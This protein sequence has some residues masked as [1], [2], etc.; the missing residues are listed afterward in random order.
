MMHPSIA[1]KYGLKPEDI[2]FAEAHIADCKRHGRDPEP[3]LCWWRDHG[4]YMAGRPPVEIAQSFRDYAERA[5]VSDADIE[6]HGVWHETVDRD[7]LQAIPPLPV[8][9]S[10]DAAIIARAEAL[11]KSD[12]R[13]YWAEQ[14][15]AMRVEYQEALAR[16][17]GTAPAPQL[18]AQAPAVSATSRSAREQYWKSG[19]G[20]RPL[21]SESPALPAHSSASSGRR[22]LPD[23][24]SPSAAIE[25]PSGDSSSLASE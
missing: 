4:Q 16:Q 21:A 2:P 5:G 25:G 24:S 17:G 8:D 3:G 15:E 18:Q 10:K 19:P 11:L 6:A 22:E 12:R 7:G 13:S 1:A 9:T 23:W 20:S 14:N